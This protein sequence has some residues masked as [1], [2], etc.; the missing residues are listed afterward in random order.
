MTK[1]VCPRCEQDWLRRVH[2]NFLAHEVILCPECDAM[3]LTHE[4]VAP[5]V[6][7]S[8][9][10]VWYDY[11]DYMRAHGRLQPESRDESTVIGVAIKEVGDAEGE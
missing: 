2:L 5:P 4:N 1:I 6:E 11:G 3:W 8:Y 10:V 9:G 7:G